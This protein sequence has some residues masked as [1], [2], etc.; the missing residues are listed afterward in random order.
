MLTH[1]SLN[2]Y[3]FNLTNYL[4]FFLNTCLQDSCQIT[5]N[6]VLSALSQKTVDQRVTRRLI[7]GYTGEKHP[8][9]SAH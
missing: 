8:R 4:P 9:A 1:H 6:L 2:Y 5:N 3:V 7:N